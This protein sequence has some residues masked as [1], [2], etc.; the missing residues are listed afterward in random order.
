MGHTG[1]N[2]RSVGPQGKGVSRFDDCRAVERKIA[3]A[4]LDRLLSRMTTEEQ[5]RVFDEF[6]Q[7]GDTQQ[8]SADERNG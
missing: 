7:A 8:R 1:S 3:Y 4:S 2:A 5:A 6:E